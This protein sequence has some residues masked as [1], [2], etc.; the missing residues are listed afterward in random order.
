MEDNRDR[1]FKQTIFYLSGVSDYSHDPEY[2]EEVD[3]TAGGGAKQPASRFDARPDEENL[4]ERLEED[5]CICELQ[6][7]DR[8]SS[9][10]CCGKKIHLSCVCP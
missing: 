3:R 9:K 10:L 6:I 1:N 2:G 7:T 4:E 8:Q 5:C